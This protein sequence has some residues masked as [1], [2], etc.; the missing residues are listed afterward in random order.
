MSL[1]ARRTVSRIARAQATPRLSVWFDRL[2]FAGR[3]LAVRFCVVV[4][5]ARERPCSIFAGICVV[6]CSEKYVRKEDKSRGGKGARRWE[7]KLINLRFFENRAA[8]F[9]TVFFRERRR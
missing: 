7:K 4:A 5:E 8:P 1:L 6:E 3:F 9:S 2:S